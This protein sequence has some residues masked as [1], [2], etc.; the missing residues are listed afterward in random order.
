MIAAPTL[1]AAAWERKR[2]VSFQA[3]K[4][5]VLEGET[6]RE[7]YLLPQEEERLMLT[8]TGRR[9]HLRDMI[10]LAINSGLREDELFSLE[11][12]DVD[13]TRDAIHVR[14][15]KNGEDRFVPMNETSRGVLVELVERARR[16]GH[17]FIFTN[18]DTSKR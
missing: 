14:K 16:N 13:F 6:N 1:L 3:W 9:S 15:S 17:S 12:R 11:V 5:V 10:I 2:D 7:R 18:P 8:L 4:E